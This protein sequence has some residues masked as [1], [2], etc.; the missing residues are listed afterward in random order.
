MRVRYSPG[1]KL[2]SLAHSRTICNDMLS[3]RNP[4]A[5]QN[6]GGSYNAITRRRGQMERRASALAAGGRIYQLGYQLG[7]SAMHRFSLHFSCTIVSFLFKFDLILQYFYPLFWS[8][9]TEVGLFNLMT[10]STSKH[11]SCHF[12]ISH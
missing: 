11:I 8:N 4:N 5:M 9:D 10:Y 7:A 6:G 1:S 12:A 2:N 3:W